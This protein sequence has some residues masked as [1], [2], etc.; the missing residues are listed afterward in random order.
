MTQL[1]IK[2]LNGPVV[3][4]FRTF[5]IVLN[6][7]FRDSVCIFSFTLKLSENIILVFG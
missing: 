1:I 7:G 5:L 6:T 4:R 3:F 2:E